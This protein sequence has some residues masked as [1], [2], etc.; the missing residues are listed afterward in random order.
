MSALRR[1]IV[2]LFAFV[3]AV[4]MVLGCTASGPATPEVRVEDWTFEAANGAARTV[5]LPSHFED[6]PK[7]RSS[8]VMRARVVL[9]PELQGRSLALRVPFLEALTDLY[10]DGERATRLDEELVVRYRRSGSQSW[11]LPPHREGELSLELRA[12]HTFTSSAYFDS[13]PRI[14]PVEESLPS[15]TVVRVM[16]VVVAIAAV[17]SLTQIGFAYL[18][19]FATDRRREPY[20]WCAAQ[21]IFATYYLLF[22]LGYTQ[23]GIGPFDLT[24]VALTLPI[25][26]FSSV[27][28]THTLFA[29]PKPSRWWLYLLLIVCLP[30]VLAPPRFW[31]LGTTGDLSVAYIGLVVSYQIVTC[32]RLLRRAEPPRGTVVV[33]LC[34]IITGITAAPDM[35]SFVG[36]GEFLGG[37]RG[38]S[39]GLTI[40]PFLQCVILSRDHIHSLNRGD[41]L[42]AELAARVQELE[43]GQRQVQSLNVELRRQIADRSRQLFAALALIGGRAGDPSPLPAGTVVQDRYRVVRELGRG[44]MGA[45][46]EVVRIADGGRFAL[47]VTHGLDVVGLARLAREAQIAAQVACP[48]VVAI[49]DIDVAV[50]GFLYLV[51]EFVDGA[52]LDRL[53]ERFADLDWTLAVLRQV[54]SGL[55]ALHAQGI[56]HR[57]LK[58]ANVLVS[59][60]GALGAPEVKLADFGISRGVAAEGAP[61]RILAHPRSEAPGS[62]TETTQLPHRPPQSLESTPLTQVGAIAG[63]PRYMAPELA[64]GPSAL[65]PL[66]DVFSFGVLAFEMLTGT[67]PFEPP[68]IFIEGEWEAPKLEDACPALESSLAELFDACIAFDPSRRPSAQTLADVLAGV[69]PA[70]SADSR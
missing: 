34:W 9:P 32:A 16:N 52:S 49:V 65:S 5:H 3:A 45:V 40:F 37:V 22:V 47:K 8:Y 26:T 51:V 39:L 44:G 69:R 33:L 56:V 27:H 38:A 21:A 61:T 2:A 29:L 58:P 43:L 59:S 20:V 54:A 13:V 24:L 18:I 66:V 60:S 35:L 55:A 64:A 63:T 4:S 17:V 6:L 19:V 1:R 36:A 53:K 14:A 10:V 7:A 28:F 23:L 31:V 70:R 62:M 15:C 67:T 41:A 11:S 48:N 25:A 12:E 30:N 50:T 57:D 42:N 46:N 68:A